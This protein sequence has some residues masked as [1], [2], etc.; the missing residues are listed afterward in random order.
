MSAAEPGGTSWRRTALPAVPALLVVVAFL[1][2]VRQGQIEAALVVTQSNNLQV[3]SAGLFALDFGLGVA[4][5]TRRTSTG[6][7]TRRMIRAGFA[8]GQLNELC[9]ATQESLGPLGTYTLFVKAGD[10]NTGTWEI[11]GANIVLDAE[12]LT[13]TLNLDGNV[14]IGI[15]AEDVT[16]LKDSAGN[17]VDNPLGV[18]AAEHR[19]GIDATYAKLSGLSANASVLDI[20]GFLTL[21][22]LEI[23]IQSGAQNC[24]APA[25]TTSWPTGRTRNDNGKCMALTGG[26]A[27]SGTDA[28]ETTCGTGAS[29][30]WYVHSDGTFRSLV[31]GRPTNCLSL[32]PAVAS[33]KTA[34]IRPCSG[35][36]D[37]QWR[38]DSAR[39]IVSTANGTCLQPAG[40]VTTDGTKLVLAACDTATYQKWDVLG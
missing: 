34:E 29:Q 17:Y 13:S 16:T 32:D 6:D 14:D 10:G 33:P 18:P 12:S 24:P 30:Q 1:L 3:K 22:N 38:V 37:Q 21:R 23:S 26:G 31:N 35:A 8:D 9:V 40:G 39:R 27:A 25:H 4:D 2:G 15:A 19:L 5:S 11:K 7:Q 20:P 28:V 36:A